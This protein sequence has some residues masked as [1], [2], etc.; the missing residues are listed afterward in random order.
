MSSAA[1]TCRA[2]GWEAI[3]RRMLTNASLATSKALEGL[4]L[5]SA[6]ETGDLIS[7]LESDLARVTRER[8]GLVRQAI[9][10]E[11]RI[12][13]DRHRVQEVRELRAAIVE[14][15]EVESMEV[16]EELTEDNLNQV[17]EWYMRHLGACDRLRAIAR[18]SAL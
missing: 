11:A 13:R 12:D 15:V 6:D 4:I 8:D 17:S 1:D 3:H 5:Q 14:W 10:D 7:T 9:L 2:N 18:G 16:P